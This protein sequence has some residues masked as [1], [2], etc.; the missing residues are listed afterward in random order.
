MLQLY[1]KTAST[2]PF[3]DGWVDRSPTST[4]DMREIDVQ[5]QR[6]AQLASRLKRVKD[7]LSRDT[8]RFNAH[9]S[10]RQAKL[11]REE[12]EALDEVRLL[13]RSLQEAC[14]RAMTARVEITKVE[15]EAEIRY[16]KFQVRVLNLKLWEHLLL[17]RD[18]QEVYRKPMKPRTTPFGTF[19]HVANSMDDWITLRKKLEWIEKVLVMSNA[20]VDDSAE[21]EKI[22]LK[23]ILKRKACVIHRYN[24]LNEIFFED[25]TS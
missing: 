6:A 16:V 20:K 4:F 1:G 13:E 24:R 5:A 7:L 23:G 18:C 9:T 3:D 8:L 12:S 10:T 19:S 14:D 17:D 21:V 22:T 2:N 25:E 11:L 15:E